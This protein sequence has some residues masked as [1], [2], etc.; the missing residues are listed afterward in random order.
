MI[1]KVPPSDRNVMYENRMLGLPR[2]R[3]LKVTNNSCP[4][5]KDF[6]NAIKV[7]YA[8]YEEQYEEKQP[9]LPPYRNLSSDRAYVSNH[10]MRLETN[11][12]VK[13]N[14]QMYIH[15]VGLRSGYRRCL[16]RRKT[17]VLLWRRLRSRLTLPKGELPQ[18]YRGA[19]AGALDT[20]RDKV[21]NYRFHRLQRQH[22]PIPHREADV[23]VSRHRRCPAL[24]AI[25]SHEA[26]LLP[27]PCRLH[28]HGMPDHVSF[29]K[30]QGKTG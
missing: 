5:H 24:P 9:F 30:T 11:S 13:K 7:C 29:R 8:G 15:Q 23:R 22:Q 28:T 3:M 4:I 26:D 18:D 12:I 1:M 20:A 2:M 25:H 16:F 6:K 19:Q 17:G 27:R 21:H 14:P 10:E